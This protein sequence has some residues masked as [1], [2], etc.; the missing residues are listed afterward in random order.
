G[1]NLAK[2]DNEALLSLVK[3]NSMVELSNYVL[4]SAFRQRAS[5]IHIEA[6]KNHGTIRLRVDG[7]LR[8]LV[9]LPKQIHQALLVRIKFLSE[10]DISDMRLP[11]DGRFSIDIGS[12]N[13]NFRV[14]TCPGLHGE[15]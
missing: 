7:H 2:Q 14:S 13:Q 10:L 4:Y 1:E 8:D 3:S 15:K 6:H 9:E 12:F 5:D 11:Q